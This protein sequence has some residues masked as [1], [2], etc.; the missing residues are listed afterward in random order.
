MSFNRGLIALAW[1][2]A[3]ALGGCA[4]GPDYKA[5]ATATPPDFANARQS[6]YSEQTVQSDWWKLFK[7]TELNALVDQALRHNYDLKSALAN[8]REARALYLEAGLNL[9]PIITSHANYTDQKRS[10]GS[11]NNRNFVPRDLKLYSTGFDAFWEVDFFGRVRRDIEASH[12]EVEAQEASLQDLSVSVIAEVA[13]NY[14]E[15]RGLQNQLEVARRNADNQTRTLEITLAKLEIGRGTELDTSRASAQLDS[16]RASIPLIETGIKLAI[17]RLGVLTGQE[18]GALTAKLSQPA[19]IPQLPATIAIGSPAE[20]LRRRP[21]IRLAERT[22]AAATARIGVATADL[23]PRVTFVGTLSLE[24]STLSGLG[25]AGSDAFSAGPRISWAA[26]DLGRV[27]ARIK[28][29]DANAEANLAQYEQTVL[30]AL[31]ETENALV[32]YNQERN[33]RALLASAA[34]A[35]EKAHQL[36]HIRFKEGITDFLTVLDTELRL[37]QDQRQLAQSETSAATALVAVY[38]ALGGG[39]EAMT[40][41][42]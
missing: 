20:L 38:K 25:A 16:T 11:L 28:A 12:D 1:S 27:Y 41:K 5:P 39:W 15:L 30:N 6:E 29:A 34:Q 14:F 22:L 2:G 10:L 3:I 24:A 42:K 9:A 4:V 33:R 8:L 23:F 35:S 32:A 36:A 7:D 21:D 17:H 40:A 31:E 37:L 18:P 13:R 26:L 19:P